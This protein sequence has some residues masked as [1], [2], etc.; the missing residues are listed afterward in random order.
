MRVGV[1]SGRPVKARVPLDTDTEGET[2]TVDAA[3]ELCVGAEPVADD[4]ADLE[5]VPDEPPA[6]V[7]EL[8][9]GEDTA[10]GSELNRKGFE[11]TLGWLK[12]L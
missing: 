4:V 12:S 7:V 2:A 6:G 3:P 11:K 5:M 1:S 8:V 10:A 9:T